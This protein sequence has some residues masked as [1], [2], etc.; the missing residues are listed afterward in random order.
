MPKRN[1]TG[2]RMK[3][4][5]QEFFEQ[6]TRKVA[7]AL[8]G[9]LLI[10]ELGGKRTSGKIVEAEAYLPCTDSACHATKHRTSRTEIM[11]GRAGVAYVYPIHAK[12]CFNIVTELEGKGCAVLIRALE[13][14]T[15]IETMQKRRGIIDLKRLTTGPSCLCQAMGIERKI[16]GVDVCKSKKVFIANDQPNRT[17]KILQTVRIGVTSAEELK[18]R[19]VVANNPYASGPKRLRSK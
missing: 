14:L 19:Y 3:P 18:L 8:L 1:N 7:R 16:N 11:F 9:K 15:G 2:K 17:D 6:S 4:L 10:S 12:F 13:P 5:Q